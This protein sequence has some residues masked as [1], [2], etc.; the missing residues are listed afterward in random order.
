MVGVVEE[1]EGEEKSKEE[2]QGAETV[3]CEQGV[4][5]NAAYEGQEGQNEAEHAPVQ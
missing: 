3:V 5:K 2:C 4:L 1:K